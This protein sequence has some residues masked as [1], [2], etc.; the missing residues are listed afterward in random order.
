MKTQEPFSINPR[1][2]NEENPGN[3]PQ[4]QEDREVNRQLVNATNVESSSEQTELAAA[5]GHLDAG[6]ELRPNSSDAALVEIDQAIAMAPATGAGRDLK[7]EAHL[8]RAG[9]LHDRALQRNDCRTVGQPAKTVAMAELNR[10][11]Q[12]KPFDPRAY[13]QAY[14]VYGYYRDTLGQWHV[15]N[16]L[17]RIGPDDP[18]P[19]ER[20]SQ[21]LLSA[22]RPAMARE[23]A[24]RAIELG[25]DNAI[26]HCLLARAAEAAGNPQGAIAAYQDYV[27]LSS[28]SEDAVVGGS[29]GNES[30]YVVKPDNWSK[31]FVF[32]YNGEG[33]DDAIF[34]A[35][36]LAESPL[37]TRILS[38]REDQPTDVQVTEWNGE[39]E[40]F[41][42]YAWSSE[43]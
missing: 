19:Y 10:A 21:I 12:V 2:V 25:S 38:G 6:R 23:E 17:T 4:S 13:W 24:A 3:Q 29:R 5:R 22:G 16:D 31:A 32:P 7:Y 15:L 8:E 40:H 1:N 39:D 41:V 27:K 26:A 37:L 42:D 35:V 28:W 34:L 36:T 33:E 14:D 18:V 20:R 11:I 43:V 9:A 30:C